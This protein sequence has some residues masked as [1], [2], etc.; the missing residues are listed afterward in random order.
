MT[1]PILTKQQQ[2]RSLSAKKGPMKGLRNVLAQPH[3]NYWPVLHEKDNVKLGSILIDLFPALRRSSSVTKKK[4]TEIEVKEEPEI[5]KQSLS[6]KDILNSV[7][8][9]INTVT[10][11]LERNTACCVLLDA[12]VE[13]PFLIKHIIMM[14][15]MKKVPLLLVPFFK[16]LTLENIGFKCSAFA[17]KKVVLSSDHHFY[18]L[19]NNV[20][21]I[22]K[23]YPA[24]T[25][26]LQIFPS[27]EALDCTISDVTE[28]NNSVPKENTSEVNKLIPDE[29]VYKFRSSRKE[30]IFIP[31]NAT[32]NTS[33]IQ[34]ENT[35][36]ISITNVSLNDNDNN[37]SS[38]Q[39]TRYFDFSLDKV[40]ESKEVIRK[41]KNNTSDVKMNSNKKSNNIM[42]LPLK[43]KQLRG[44]NN[45]TKATKVPKNKRYNLHK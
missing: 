44:N 4:S 15:Q 9:G 18:T 40:N 35:D 45:R 2:R 38:L 39:S 24:S 26:S 17:L 13:P 11:S 5:S 12:N 7:Y 34:E 37:V 31:P 29:N 19:Y 1:T 42:Y 20:L 16:I 27:D 8:L 10:R 30:R 23:N 21:E 22:S 41:R 25:Q 14:A 33:N 43:V 3:D 36:F 28:V 32:C 6:N